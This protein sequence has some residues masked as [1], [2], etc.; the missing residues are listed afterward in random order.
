MWKKFF[1]FELFALLIELYLVLKQKEKVSVVFAY[2]E[3]NFPF[4]LKD[5]KEG[6]EGGKEKDGL[7]EK[8]GGKDFTIQP[9]SQHNYPLPLLL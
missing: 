8:E 9:I 7:K 4:L 6:S 1:Q 3:K 5:G 2:L